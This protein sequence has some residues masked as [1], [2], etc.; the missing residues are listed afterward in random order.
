MSD[1]G[2]HGDARARQS[3]GKWRQRWQR[4]DSPRDAFGSSRVACRTVGITRGGMNSS[5]YPTSAYGKSS[6]THVKFGLM[7]IARAHCTNDV[8][9]GLKFVSCDIE[10]RRRAHK[11]GLVVAGPSDFRHNSGSQLWTKEFSPTGG[12][13]R[14][15]SPCIWLVVVEK[16]LVDA[17]RGQALENVAAVCEM[18][19]GLELLACG[20]LNESESIGG[21]AAALDCG[22]VQTFVAKN[23]LGARLKLPRLSNVMPMPLAAASGAY[24]DTPHS[25]CII[26]ELA[27]Q[28]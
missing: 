13:I 27:L 23:D 20:L 10:L 26:R 6:A 19:L 18:N 3:F 2:L 24:V 15:H 5:L 4:S 17:E 22:A 11:H 12:A 28:R 8:V 1:I 21:L 9:T 7:I 16:R 14:H 25:L